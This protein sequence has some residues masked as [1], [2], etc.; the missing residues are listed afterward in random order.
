[1][2]FSYPQISERE[3]KAPTGKFR[4]VAVDTFAGP[5]YGTPYLMGDYDSLEDA[6][7][8]AKSLDEPY[9]G[10]S[11]A[12]HTGKVHYPEGTNYYVPD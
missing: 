7:E 3:R 6:I 8:Q 9:M 5:G 12:D 4:A 11:V 10:G 1:M 2:T